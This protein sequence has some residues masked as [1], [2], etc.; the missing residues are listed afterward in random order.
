MASFSASSANFSAYSACLPPSE[1]SHATGLLSSAS[2]IVSDS[3]WKIALSS[4][5]HAGGSPQLFSSH[6]LS[7]CA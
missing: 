4:P 6:S 5:I 3:F 7:I 1:I 2:R